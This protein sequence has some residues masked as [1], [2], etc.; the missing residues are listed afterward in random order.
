MHSA[1][2]A[3]GLEGM[4]GL[5][6]PP[7]PNPLP[8]LTQAVSKP[9][10]QTKS[11][12]G[13]SFFSIAMVLMGISTVAAVAIPLWFSRPEITLKGAAELLVKDIQQVQEHA[14]ILRIGCRIEFDSHGG[15][16]QAMDA[17]GLALP[18]PMTGDPYLRDYGQD[19]VFE[20][21]KIKEANFG[22]KRRLEFGA[23]GYSLQDGYVLLSFRGE[24]RKVVF[25][26]N[27]AYVQAENER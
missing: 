4:L 17:T 16:Y 12:W 1:F 15:G 19:A 25:D 24:T 2:A 5:P 8:A 10:S 22:G 13:F 14:I 18:A 7:H 21:V 27:Q 11:P 23:D 9:T 6:P 26:L 3:T 20:G